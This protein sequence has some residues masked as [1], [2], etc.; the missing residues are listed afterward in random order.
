MCIFNRLAAPRSAKFGLYLI[1]VTLP[2]ACSRSNLFNEACHAFRARHIYTRP[3]TSRTNGKAERFIQTLIREW[4]YAL[5]YPSSD[6][7]AADLPR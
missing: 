5:P 6:K 4:A 3:Y 2:G 7:R 1:N